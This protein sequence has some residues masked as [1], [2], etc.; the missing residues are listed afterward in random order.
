ME[1]FVQFLLARIADNEA[2]ARQVQSAAKAAVGSAS[3]VVVG[4]DNPTGVDYD[5]ARVL[6]DCKAKRLIVEAYQRAR[7]QALAAGAGAGG[8]G[9]AFGLMRAVTLLAEVYADHPDFQE[10]WLP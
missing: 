10:D 9:A 6:A 1:D 5:P 7:E 8:A 2:A 3:W 4:A